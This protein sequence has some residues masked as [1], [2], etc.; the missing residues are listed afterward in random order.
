MG[1][2]LSVLCLTASLHSFALSSSSVLHTISIDTYKIY[3]SVSYAFTY[4]S[5][6]TYTY[7]HI[8]KYISIHTLLTHTAYSTKTPYNNFGPLLFADIYDS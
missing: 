3:N 4:K 1:G 5:I 7:K 8:Y 6:Y 2:P